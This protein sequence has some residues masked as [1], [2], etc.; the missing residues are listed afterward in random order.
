MTLKV[1]QRRP[2]A[3]AEPSK[4]TRNSRALL[5]PSAHAADLGLPVAFVI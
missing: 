5:S 4:V 2:G 1:M 3:P